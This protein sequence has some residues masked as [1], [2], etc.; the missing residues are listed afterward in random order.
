MTS[1]LVSS[2]IRTE[3]KKFLQLAI[4]L[5][6]A[7]VAQSLTGFFDTI[8]MGRLGGEIL[9]G[10][11]LASLTFMALLTIASGVVMGISP[12]IAEADGAGNRRKIEQLVRQGFWLVLLLTIP[13]MIAI[14]NFDSLMVQLG[15]A[16]TTVTLANTYLD[17]ILWGFFPALGFAMLRGMVSGLSHTR[18]VMFI[19]ILGTFFNI[20]GNYILG[21]GKFGFPRL[22][23]AGLA[24]ASTL[25]LWGMF[26]A[27]LIYI[28][29]HP[30]LK[31][32]QIIKG[33][34]RLKPSILAELVKIGLPIGV[35][36]ALEIGL[37]TVVTYLMGA[38]G[39]DVLAAHQ[40]IFQTIVV[41]FMIPLGMS[42]AATVRVGQW[43][44]QKNLEGIRRSGYLSIG[45][46]LGFIIL[47][48][49]AML[50]F[51]QAIVS[52]YLDID[53]PANAE[54]LALALPMLTIATVS[55]IPDVIQKITYGALQGIQDTRVPILL[56][57]P[58]FWGVGLAGGY[59]LGFP[60]GWGGTGLWLGHFIGMAIAAML[61]LIRF[62]HQITRQKKFS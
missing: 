56:S 10:G 51:P 53:D 27:L 39:T 40:I 60:L 24:L 7:Q 42:Y 47:I 14:A 9:A 21:F 8:M 41:I 30:Q 20:T 3:I 46:G 34:N 54:I 58:S 35:F 2:L 44:G 18:P 49:I 29:K 15:Q 37:F 43:L 36:S 48:T 17:I 52:L 6:S 12:L 23:L 4:P 55:Q 11:G 32:Y 26:F 28:L 45:I 22:G 16:E 1:N 59:I 57:I 13:M 50:L 25:A 19:V 31:T 5:A 33:L 62:H 38:L 61:F